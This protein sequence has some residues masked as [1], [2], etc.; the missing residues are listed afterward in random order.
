MPKYNSSSK[1][2]K[3]P[4]TLELM[5]FRFWSNCFTPELKSNDQTPLGF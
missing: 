1:V 3:S 4:F 5:T 2:L